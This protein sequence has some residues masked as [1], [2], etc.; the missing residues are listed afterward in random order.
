MRKFLSLFTVLVLLYLLA[1]AQTRTVSGQ[2]KDES[3]GA[4]IGFASIKVKGSSSGVAAD[5]NGNFRIDV[6]SG[7]SLVVSAAGYD[8]FTVKVGSESTL[9]LTLKSKNTSLQEVVVT[10]LG[11]QRQAR[12]LGYST[13]KVSA[14]ELTQAKP[15][16]V[17]NG[18]T[19]KVAGLQINTVNNGLF[20][21]TRVILRGNRSLTGNN[22]PLIVVDGA[23]YYNDIS[24][25]NPED[26]QETNILKGSSAAAVYGSDASNGVIIITTKHG[27]RGKPS[28]TASATGQLETVSYLPDLQN[29]FGSNGGEVFVNDL[30]DYSSY[31]PY[32]NQSYGP[33]YNGSVIVPIGRPLS[34]GTTLMVPYAALKNEKRKFFD[35]ALTTQYNVSYSA[36]DENSRFFIS[37]Q[38]IHSRG[39]VPKDEGRRDVFRVG[40]SK[41]YGIFSANYSLSY[42]HK[43]TDVTN[44]GAVYQLVMNTPAHV[45]LTKLKDWQHYKYADLNGFYNDYFDNPYWAIDNYRNKTTD[46]VLAG[47]VQ[48]NLKPLSWLNLSYRLSMNNLSRRFAYSSGVKEY[49]SYAQTSSTVIYAKPN[50]NGYDTVQESPKYNAGFPAQATYNTSNYTNFLVTSD[51][52]VNISKDIS[53]DFSVDGTLGTSYIDNKTNYLSAN[54]GYLFFPVY[55]VNSLTGIPS[56][57]ETNLEARKLGFFGEATLGFRK[58]AFVHGSYRTDI[59]SRLSKDNRYIPYYD[60]DASLVVSDLIPAMANSPVMNYVKVRAAHSLT[61]N[62]SA[63]AGG[64]PYIA[65]GAYKT[66]STLNSAPGF[67]FSGLGGYQLNSTIANP[68]IKPETVIENEVGLEMG[69]LNDNLVVRLAAYQSE[70]KDGIVYAQL[71]RSTGSSQALI[72]AANT[73]NKGFEAEVSYNV[74]KTK[75]VTWR[76]GANYTYNESK[77]V[78]INGDVPS[79]GLSGAN[80]NSFAVVGQAYPVIETRDWKR[81]AD[82]H[83]IVDAMT[84]QPSQDPKLKVLGQATPKHIV[85]I[86]TNVTW[87]SLSLAVTADY[88]GGYKIF[89]SIGQ[90]MDFT[91]ISSTTAATGRERFVVPNS[92]YWD[93]SKYVPNT[94]IAIDDANFNFWPGLYRSIG[95]NYVISAAAWKLREVSLAYELPRKWFVAT[96]VV[97]RATVALSGRNLLMIRP[98]TNKWTDPEF[99]ED[100][101]NDVGRT[102]EN[103]A[104]PTRIFSATLSLTF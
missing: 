75:N 61:G 71:A 19:G 81:D 91:G 80:G 17:V 1:P 82:N 21:P 98:S 57:G 96:R 45:P 55:N 94:N 6:P 104:P 102:S 79:L 2:I 48:L 5:E 43:T 56:L 37:G 85:G 14:R 72:N 28:L 76:I 78:K 84:G 90:Y 22:Q 101:G 10:A 97:Q 9:N 42:T 77:V 34:D 7:T 39:V 58:F 53:R 86:S 49:S 30:N 12:E 41:T 54:A 66:V 67:P 11:I 32:E 103:Q 16:S 15:I 89:N 70:L 60:I 46:N 40:G 100:T 36:G 23:I 93:G 64:S 44:T 52:F 31:V 35:N 38:D 99:N 62:T 47:N 24:T 33:Q 69:L 3:S 26:I 83:I 8:D 88:R 25:L 87:K 92:V 68:N 13:S 65:D 50:G 95:A 51:F 27:T 20:A 74:L 29:R 59:D 73:K 63:L 18:L 4:P